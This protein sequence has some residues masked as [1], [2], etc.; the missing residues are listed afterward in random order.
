MGN[1]SERELRISTAL[2]LFERTGVMFR[3][4]PKG[5]PMLLVW[6]HAI[7]FRWLADHDLIGIFESKNEA[8]RVVRC[9][10]DKMDT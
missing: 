10:H 6:S 8:V 5:H 9:M 3:T 1:P 2:F 4:N 7:L